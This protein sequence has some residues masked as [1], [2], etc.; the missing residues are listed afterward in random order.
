ME[1]EERV[2]RVID[3]YRHLYG[4][5]KMRIPRRPDAR[6]P[7]DRAIA[8]K[9]IRWCAE[10]DTDEL[11][12]MDE[13][14][15][16]LIALKKIA[17]M[18]RTLRSE[19][20]MKVWKKGG[21]YYALEQQASERISKTILPMFDQTILDL[22]HLTPDQERYQRRHFLKGTLEICLL[23]PEH[24]GGF[25]PASKVCPKCTNGPACVARINARWKF[26]VVALRAN[27]LDLVPAQVAKV[28]AGG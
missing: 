26:N 11:L 8:D 16:H 24:S 20:V 21:E 3:H 12:F 7:E 27:R 23:M 15:R 1:R 2:K 10:Y 13:R 4:K 14:F 18:F 17:P 9:Y 6:V 25:H 28:A 5:Y 19:P 22:S